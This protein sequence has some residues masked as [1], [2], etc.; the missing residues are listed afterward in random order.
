MKHNNA[1]PI[2]WLLVIVFS[3]TVCRIV[4]CKKHNNM[5]GCGDSPAFLTPD[6]KGSP[7]GQGGN[8]HDNPFRSLTI[9]PNNPQLIYVGSEGS[10]VFRSADGGVSWQWLRTG[11][12]HCQD[13]YAETYNIAIDP[14]NSAHLLMATEEGPSKPAGYDDGIYASSDSGNHWTQIINGLTTGT[15]SSVAISPV[16][17]NVCFAGLAGG[18]STDQNNLGQLFYGGI[19]NSTNGG[20]N[21]QPLY[22]TPPMNLD[23]IFQIEVRGGSAGF[24]LFTMGALSPTAHGSQPGGLYKASENG[25]QWTS[26]FPAALNQTMNGYMFD[27]SQDQRYLYVDNNASGTPEITIRSSDSGATWIQTAQAGNGPIRIVG[28]NPNNVVYASYANIYKSVDGMATSALAFNGASA[29]LDNDVTDI[30]V[31]RTNPAIVYAAA[32]GLLI[33]KST[34]GGASFTQIANL[35]NYINTH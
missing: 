24:S 7:I 28:T 33:Y 11:L 20:N 22:V 8:D 30:E 35:R 27:V 5:Q 14:G 2:H 32:K 23:A 16:D 21:W 9:D 17:P 13:G 12:Y 34:D 19:F 15:V 10:G 1:A 18:G 26:L 4:A 25:T 31:A 6:V 3:I 29:N